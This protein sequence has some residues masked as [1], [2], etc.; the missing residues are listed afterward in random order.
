MQ[1]GRKSDDSRTMKCRYTQHHIL[2]LSYSL[3]FTECIWTDVGYGLNSNRQPTDSRLGGAP[4]MP[5]L[6][7]NIKT[8]ESYS[9][10][11]GTNSAF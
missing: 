3:L 11:V 5:L 8:G 1:D 9:R 10:M 2:R 6:P 7:A 4:Y